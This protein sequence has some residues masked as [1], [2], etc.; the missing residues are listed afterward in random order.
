MDSAKLSAAKLWLT[1]PAPPGSLAPSPAAN[2]PISAQVGFT[3][4]ISAS[5]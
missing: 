2:G 4:Q 3:G 5:R 1:S